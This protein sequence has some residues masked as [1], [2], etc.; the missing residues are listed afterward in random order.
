VKTDE[1]DKEMPWDERIIGQYSQERIF[2]AKQVKPGDRF[3]FR[4][5]ELSLLSPVTVAVEVKEPEL[6]DLLVPGKEGRKAERI[7]RNLIRVE[8]IPE[9][10]MVGTQAIQLPKMVVWLG[11]QREMVRSEIEMP[12][13][14]KITLYRTTKV[15]AQ[16]EG[17]APSLLPDLGLTTLI[18]LD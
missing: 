1:G 16:E 15:I 3:T 7:Q 11:D 8:V 2:R 18:P 6:V 12:G 10:V 17:A 13:L 5:Y 4:N 14:G 9:K